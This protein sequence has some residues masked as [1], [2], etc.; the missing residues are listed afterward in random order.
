MESRNANRT[1]MRVW[2]SSII[3]IVL[4]I[5]FPIFVYATTQYTDGQVSA[6][7]G[8]VDI[9]GSLGV[10]TGAPLTEVTIHGGSGE[11]DAALTFDVDGTDW[12]IGV[13]DSDAD[14]FKIGTGS[15]VGT[16]QHVVITTGGDVGIGGG[17]SYRLDVQE[18]DAASYAV[19]FFNDGSNVNRCGLIIQCG[20]DSGNGTLMSLRDGNGDEQG[21]ITFAVDE[22]LYNTFTANHDARI[23]ETFNEKG[24]PY[25][26][27]MHL[28]T[29]EHNPE[30]P[31]QVD[32][33]VEP[34]QKS[35]DKTVFGIYSHKHADK[36]NLHAIFALGDG[37]ILVTK[38]GG[39]I[40]IGDYLTSSS[41][42][43]HAM[44]Q[45]D[46]LLHGYTIAKATEAVTWENE[47]SDSKLIS[48]T[49]HA[50]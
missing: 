48:C 46:D 17:P 29:I 45:D 9:V 20:Q 7:G 22:V 35:Y 36:K 27:V 33:F 16:N 21:T 42:E 26:T 50:Q 39:N 25:G 30:R 2:F 31:H 34:S 1:A 5:C 38:E 13:D 18:T 14:S 37:H 4:C 3:F 28:E 49:Y 11:N 12:Y 40:E 44:K 15:A 47:S 23:P 19:R 32:Y 43:G 24:Y 8:D 41:I 10:D 6:S